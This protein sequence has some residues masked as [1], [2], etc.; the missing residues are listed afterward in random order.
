MIFE[1]QEGSIKTP[2][3]ASREREREGGT[4]ANEPPPF[5]HRVWSTVDPDPG[6]GTETE[7]CSGRAVAGNSARHSTHRR[8]FPLGPRPAAV[9][10]PAL[11]TDQRRA[12]GGGELYETFSRAYFPRDIVNSWWNKTRVNTDLS[13]RGTEFFNV[14]RDL[15]GE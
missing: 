3:C 7:Q 8:A 2:R 15:R 13:S 5:Y 10:L 9:C 14:D 12:A 6:R 11:I 4:L 1:P